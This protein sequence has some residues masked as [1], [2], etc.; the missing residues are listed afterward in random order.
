LNLHNQSSHWRATTA[1]YNSRNPEMLSSPRLR[2]LCCALL[3]ICQMTFAADWRTPE[4]QLAGKI[5]AATGPGVIALEINNRSSI[6]S[7]EVEA[8]RRAL[9]S[10]LAGAGIRVWDPDQAAAVVKITLSES[11]QNY[12]WVAEIQQG[13]SEPSLVLISAPR[14]ESA[15]NSQNAAP[16]TLRVTPLVSS[17]EPILDAAVLEG[18]PRRVLALGAGGVA[19][20]DFKDNRWVQAQELAIA[21][22]HPFPRDLRGRI[23][24]RNDHLFDAYLPGLV[25]HSTNAAPLAITCLPSDDPWPLQTPDFGVSAFFSPAQNFFTG[26]LA[27][28]IGTQRAAPSFYSA[29]T[30]PREKYALWIFAGID[31]QLHL[32][33]GINQQTLGN[34]R[35]GSDIAGMHAD[36][37][38]AWQVLSTSSMNETTDSVQAFEFPDRQPVAVSQKLEVNGRVTALWTAQNGQGAV[39]VYRDADNGNYEAVQLN[40]TCGQ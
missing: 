39:A 4:L 33:D 17:P 7:A 29:A 5:A 27:P 6:S 10:D 28:G 40:L 34:I 32:L 23:I 36:C 2:W 30:V 22:S 13:T 8:I 25:C 9:I 1:V 12:V 31:R 14:P 37:R 24:L 11:L 38:P 18:S 19:I 20:Y 3:I 15:P 21:H 16:F 35:W 26:A